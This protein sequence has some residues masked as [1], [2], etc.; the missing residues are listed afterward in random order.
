LKQGATKSG[1]IDSKLTFSI[2]DW[3][4]R[5]LFKFKT[6]NQLESTAKAN[7]DQVIPKFH[8]RVF[9]NE[10]SESGFTSNKLKIFY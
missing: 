3:I 6:K 8:I 2:L 4:Y 1:E 9:N 5:D 10:P 7:K